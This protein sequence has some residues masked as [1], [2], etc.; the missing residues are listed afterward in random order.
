[1]SLTPK[2]KT[3]LITCWGYIHIYIYICVCVCVA[4][5][6]IICN[7]FINSFRCFTVDEMFIM[8]PLMK[9][10]KFSY[11]SYSP[12]MLI[13]TQ[14]ASGIIQL[15]ESNRQRQR[16]TYAT[17]TYLRTILK[18]ILW[19]S[20]SL[21]ISIGPLQIGNHNFM[22]L[23][24]APMGIYRWPYGPY[25][26]LQISIGPLKSNQHFMEMLRAPMDSYTFLEIFLYKHMYP[27]M[28]ALW[29]AF[30]CHRAHMATYRFPQGPL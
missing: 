15:L 25:G 21:Q 3:F 16:Q 20:G 30:P 12:Q 14:A 24:G 6:E 22:E 7:S 1:M 2:S 27:S 13:N 8:Y 29:N 5:A 19:P 11:G 26:N 18:I 10:L 4:A 23:C 9:F 17:I 28:G